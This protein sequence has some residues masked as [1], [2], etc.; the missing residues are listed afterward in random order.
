M[1]V[2]GVRRVLHAGRAATSDRHDAEAARRIHRLPTAAR[3]SRNLTAVSTTTWPTAG[4]ITIAGGVA[5]TEGI[6]HTGIGPFDVDNASRLTYITL[7]YPKGGAANR[8]FTNM[9]HGDA[10]QPPDARY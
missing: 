4:K 6:I 1:V 2:Q 7:R 3:R 10:V 8:F 9:L 5:G